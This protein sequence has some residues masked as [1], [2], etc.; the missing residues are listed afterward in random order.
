MHSAPNNNQGLAQDGILWNRKC[1]SSVRSGW[2]GK[3][4]NRPL[5]WRMDYL[6]VVRSVLVKRLKSDDIPFIIFQYKLMLEL[7]IVLSHVVMWIY[8]VIILCW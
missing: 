1:V 4:W 3:C 6:K 8:R 7:N 2:M 5:K